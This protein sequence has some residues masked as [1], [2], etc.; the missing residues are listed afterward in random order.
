MR[1]TINPY[2]MKKP[3]LLLIVICICLFACKKDEIGNKF[4]ASYQ[5]WVA[6][7]NKSNNS[8]T[9]TAYQYSVFGPYIETKFTIKNGK[10]TALEYLLGYY[11][12]PGDSL[13]V[14]RTWSENENTLNV[15]SDVGHE[16]LTLDEVYNKAK[17]VWLKADPAKNHIYFEIA[18]EGMISEAGYVPNGCQDDCLNG[19]HIKNI[20]RL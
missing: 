8:Y 2:R 13:T 6:F 18:N 20:S 17:T 14:I 19:I 7:K 1:N 11:K 15:H 3:Y 12:S 16:L 9:Y 10:L 5:K 4:N